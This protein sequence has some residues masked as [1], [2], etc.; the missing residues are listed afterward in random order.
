MSKITSKEEF[1]VFI[2]SSNFENSIFADLSQD[3][4]AFFKGQLRF[5]ADGIPGGYWGDIAKAGRMN[6][7]ELSEFV[8]KYFNVDAETFE[9]CVNYFGDGQGNC[10][11]R[12]QFNC[13]DC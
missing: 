6:D 11:Y 5:N 3:D 7:K 1:E 12:Y 10:T 4:L 13:P 8:E 2:N 9:K